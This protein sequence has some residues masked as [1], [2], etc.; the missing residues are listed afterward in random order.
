[1]TL[2]VEDTGGSTITAALLDSALARL[3]SSCPALTSLYLRGKRALSSVLTPSIGISCPLLKSLAITDVENVQFLQASLR[4]LPTIL[5]RVTCL[6]LPCHTYA[7]P[8]MSHNTNILSL[9]IGYIKS[10]GADSDWNSLP[11]KLQYLRCGG[12]ETPPPANAEGIFNN[13]LHLDIFNH[14][15]HLHIITE[16]PQIAPNLQK[17]ACCSRYG[18]SENFIECT[19]DLSSAA[20]MTLLQSMQ[21]DYVKNAIFFIHCRGSNLS[22]QVHHWVSDSS[23]MASLPRMTNVGQCAFCDCKLG[24]LGNLLAVFPKMHYLTLKSCKAL[25]DVELQVLAGSVQLER[26]KLMF[27]DQVSPM[28]LF[29]LCQ[30]LPNLKVVKCVECV[31]LQAAALHVCAQLLGRNISI[32]EAGEEDD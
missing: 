32:E 13:L 21:Q 5:P 31:Q 3:V 26:L 22:S 8:D 12:I 10:L 2:L 4:L 19:L 11:P 28:G 30:L 29:A 20:E 6:E 1:M 24:H 14:H 7:L 23:F 15:S 16:L 9:D 25:D 18:G 27:C 17:Y